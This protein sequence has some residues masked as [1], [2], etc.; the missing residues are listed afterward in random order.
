MLTTKQQLLFKG[1]TIGLLGG[2]FNPPHEGHL[3]IS[4]QALQAFGLNKIWW[5]VSPGNPMKNKPAV[6]LNVR[7]DKCKKIVKNPDIIIS[8][9][10][11]RLRTRLTA[12]TLR[13]LFLFYPGVRFI[14]LMGADNLV[15]FHKWESWTWIMENIPMGVMARPGEQVKAGLSQTAFRY[16]KFRIRTSEAAAIPSMKAPAW[17]LLGGPMRDLSSTQIRSRSEEK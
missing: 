1:T 3:H 7:I 8:D 16:K 6:S 13:K 9:I 15:N 2:S 4:H 11:S 5:L 12:H 14:W 17:S 10:E